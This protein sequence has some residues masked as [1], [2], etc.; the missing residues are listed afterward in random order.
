MEASESTKAPAVQP[1]QR[2]R[3]KRYGTGEPEH[4]MTPMK[5]RL[6]RF[7]AECGLLSTPQVAALSGHTMKSA[8]KHLRDLQDHELVQVVAV[9][10]AA[11]SDWSENN[12]AALLYGSA[13]KVYQPT[14]EGLHL[15][16]EEGLIGKREAARP[17]PAY[18]PKN[19]LFLAHELE[20]RDVR[21][22]LEMLRH[23]HP[24]HAGVLD[25]RDGTD[26]EIALGPA[27][28]AGRPVAQRR[29]RPDAWFVYGLRNGG[30]LV[31]LVETDRGTERG[32]ERWEQK[33][34]A[35]ADLYALGE[36]IR[37]V[38]GQQSARVLVMTP[39]AAR[40]EW[41]TAFLDERLAGAGVP[42]DR[43]WLAERAV[44]D[45]TDLSR[46]VWRVPGRDALMPLVPE[47]F[48]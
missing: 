29:A 27:A 12:D 3:R 32:A 9:P 23:A 6:L 10:R 1:A 20:V 11:L 36:R 34:T 33:V 5:L 37:E 2:R 18:G 40:R 14:R 39:D 16:F 28:P 26:A 41:L 8:Y 13:P 17:I 42:P 4:P 31:G 30:K 15:L 45:D 38:T 47:K 19:S 44:L 22:W 48:R 46:A 43:F 35:Y 7:V 24:E 21:V 25:W